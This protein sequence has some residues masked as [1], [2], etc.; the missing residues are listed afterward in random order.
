MATELNDLLGET[1]LA[2]NTD[3]TSES[4][5]QVPIDELKNKVLAIYFSAHWCPPCQ[6]FTPKLA[7]CY[8][9]IQSE[10]HDKFDII[11]VSSDEDETSFDEYFR[12]MPWKALR[13]SDRERSKKLSK[14]FNVDGI[15]TLIVLLAD[16]NLLTENG[17]NDIASKGAEAVRSWVQGLLWPGISCNAC[18]MNPLVGQRYNCS[19]CD[20]YNLC[21]ACQNNGHEHELTLMSP[22]LST[23][24]EIVW[25]GIDTS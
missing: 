17:R 8:K 4:Y 21:F 5:R 18:Q 25:K 9:K 16:G 3:V 20:K 1:L 7:E 2:V 23:I 15:P 19:T 24:G 12:T 10:L 11:F 22:E 13:Y 14:K 6:Q